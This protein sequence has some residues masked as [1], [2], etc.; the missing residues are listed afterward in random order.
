[1]ILKLYGWLVDVYYRLALRY[2]EY[3]LKKLH[4]NIDSIDEETLDKLL[5]DL[6]GLEEN[7]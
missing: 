5:N 3:Q 1:M 6:K 2:Y 4:D 7:G